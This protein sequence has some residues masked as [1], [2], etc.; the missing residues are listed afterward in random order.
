[1]TQAHIR[2]RQ[3]LLASFKTGTTGE[4]AAVL[5]LVHLLSS[6]VKTREAGPDFPHQAGSGS[7]NA[8]TN[9]IS[10]LQ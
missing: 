3:R 6:H 10:V 4:L 7:K 9:S 2:L 1:M 5:Q 8:T